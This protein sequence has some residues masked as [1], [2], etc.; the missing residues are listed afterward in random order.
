MNQADIYVDLDG[1]AIL[2]AGLDAEERRLVARLRRRARTHPDWCDFDNYW[3]RVVLAFY[4]A[5]GVSRKRVVRTVPFQIA[6][7]LRSR[8]GIA[9]GLVRPDDC[10]GDLETLIREKFDSEKAFCKATGLQEEELRK[11]LAGRGDLSVNALE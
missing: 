5:R 2:L 4:N 8:L 9:T 1:E 6:Q 10:E 3:M 7:D 11:Y